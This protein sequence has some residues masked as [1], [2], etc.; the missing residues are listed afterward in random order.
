[1]KNITLSL[2]DDL[3]EAGRSYAAA[4]GTSLNALVR[5]LLGQRVGRDAGAQRDRVLQ[6][7]QTHV[8]D[9]AGK[10]WTR[11]ELYDDA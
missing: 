1:M 4:H 3:L 7:A 10:Q 11:A 2:D 5:E 8:G 6:L 9:S